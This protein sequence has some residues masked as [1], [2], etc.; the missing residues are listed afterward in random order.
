MKN[1][2]FAKKKFNKNDYKSIDKLVKYLKMTN[3][4]IVVIGIL[5]VL[6]L[7]TYAGILIN[8]LF[9][10]ENIKIEK[11][12]SKVYTGFKFKVKEIK[13]NQKGYG[14]YSACCIKD[15]NIKFYIYKNEQTNEIYDDFSQQYRKYYIEKIGDTT[16]KNSLTINEKKV[17]YYDEDFLSDYEFWVEINNYEEIQ[18]ATTIL[19]KLHQYF[20]QEAK[21]PG[22]LLLGGEIRQKSS[23]YISNGSFEYDMT[24]SQLLEREKENYTKHMSR[25]L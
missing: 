21:I 23:G 11:Y 20:Y 9:Y 5:V 12:L 7:F 19:Y 1:K 14:L 16:M 15:S 22:L 3:K 18:K 6:S 25:N 10:G 13:V 4:V 2:K 24:L 17:K 8:K